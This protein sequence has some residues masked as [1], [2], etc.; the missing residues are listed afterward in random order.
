MAATQNISTL[1]LS[2]TGHRCN[3]SAITECYQSHSIDT[4]QLYTLWQYPYCWDKT[5]NTCSKCKLGLLV[6]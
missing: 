3:L 1:Y 6:Q 2:E 5:R 4:T